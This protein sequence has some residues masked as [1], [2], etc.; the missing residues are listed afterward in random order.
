MARQ[1]TAEW[2]GDLMTGGGLMKLGSGA[3]E[4]RYSFSTRF[5]DQ[6]GV[7]PEEL[8]GAALASCYAMALANSLAMAGSVAKRVHATADVHSGK[9]EK[10]YLITRIDLTVTAEVPGLDHATFERYAEETKTGCIIARALGAT[11]ITLNATLA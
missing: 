7:N 6:A 3:Y 2:N 5:G 9:D 10:G 4:G 8:V 1:A 11:P